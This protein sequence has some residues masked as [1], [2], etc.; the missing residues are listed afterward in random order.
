MVKVIDEKLLKELLIEL[1]SYQGYSSFTNY[2]SPNY[3]STPYSIGVIAAKSPEG[4]HVY[5]GGYDPMQLLGTEEVTQTEHVYNLLHLL[6]EVRELPES[7][8][9][10]KQ[11][12]E[13]ETEEEYIQWLYK[14]I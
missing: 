8:K 5:Y 1:G 7:L 13:D 14:T 12:I 10:L 2:L 3:F 9:E 11:T 4:Y 6:E